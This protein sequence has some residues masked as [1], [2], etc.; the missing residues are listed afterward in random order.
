MTI[1]LIA[2]CL[3]L[4]VATTLVADRS[5]PDIGSA[6]PDSL[7]FAVDGQRVDLSA[8]NGKIRVITF[9]AS[10]CAPCLHEIPV[11]NT[12]QNRAGL[13]RLQVIAVNL[14]QS[15][16]RILAIR[17]QLEEN[18]LIWVRDK[19]GSVGKRF[20][21]EGIPHLI[22]V[23]TDGTIAHRHIGYNESALPQIVA[24]LNALIVKRFSPSV[25]EPPR[26][27]SP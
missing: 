11:L 22:I 7:G 1:R 24:E 27:P 13:D 19:R 8:S 2:V 12:I 18:G 26:P 10:W 20:G 6:A 3:S 23:D 4:L 9:W 16:R 17:D 25:S 14:Q 5:M 15:K 21:V